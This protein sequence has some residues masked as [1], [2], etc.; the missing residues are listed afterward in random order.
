LKLAEREPS[1]LAAVGNAIGFENQA[2]VSTVRRAADGDR[3]RPV[4][5]EPLS[6]PFLQFFFI[7][8]SSAGKIFRARLILGRFDVFPGFSD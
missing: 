8:K 5:I 3:P 6:F 4:Q 2:G 7:N 1:R